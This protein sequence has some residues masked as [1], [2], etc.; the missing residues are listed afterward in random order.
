MKGFFCF[1]WFFVGGNM[2]CLVFNGIC[3]NCSWSMLFGILFGEVWCCCVFWYVMYCV[4][5]FWFGFWFELL[6]FVF[7]F[8]WGFDGLG[9]I[10][11]GDWY[12]RGLWLFNGELFSEF[13][14]FWLLFFILVMVWR[15]LNCVILV[16]RFV[17]LLEVFF[18]KGGLSWNILGICR[19]CFLYVKDR[20]SVGE[21]GGKF[22]F[23]F[24]V[25]WNV[26]LVVWFRGFKGCCMNF[27]VS[28]FCSFGFIN[29][30]IVV[31]VCC[32]FFR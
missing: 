32:C 1:G 21:Y 30:F 10:E 29:G 27:W 5:V 8:I 6:L 11:N 26:F 13:V 31:R 25:F 16:V 24:K 2:V 4:M 14:W 12:I 18:F 17:G 15:V 19:I 20:F 23:N 7:L 3:N 28:I 22:G 9:E